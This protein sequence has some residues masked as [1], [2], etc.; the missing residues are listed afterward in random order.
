MFNQFTFPGTFRFPRLGGVNPNS[1]P[2]L[3]ELSSLILDFDTPL[4]VALKAKDRL[5]FSLRLDFKMER[6][7]SR[8]IEAF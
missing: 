6:F 7:T 3:I 1:F 5:E 4:F 8:D 2:K